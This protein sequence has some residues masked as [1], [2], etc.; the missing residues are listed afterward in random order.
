MAFRYTNETSVE[1]TFQNQLERLDRMLEEHLSEQH[2]RMHEV[3][4]DAYDFTPRSADSQT[5]AEAPSSS[6]AATE[7]STEADSATSVPEAESSTPA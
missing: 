3:E 5:P 1:F 2:A 6:P 7:S 4:M